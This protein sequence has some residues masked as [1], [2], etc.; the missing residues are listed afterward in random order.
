MTPMRTGPIG[1]LYGYCAT[2]TEV[3]TDWGKEAQPP[4]RCHPHRV[5]PLYLDRHQKLG[6]TVEGQCAQPS[7]PIARARPRAAPRA[8]H[9][10]RVRIAP[11]PFAESN[12][13]DQRRRLVPFIWSRAEDGQSGTHKSM[14]RPRLR[15]CCRADL[16]AK[17]AERDRC[18]RAT[19]FAPACTSG[20]RFVSRSFNEA[21]PRCSAY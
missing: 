6:K 15:L 13:K 19:Y 18:R 4:L 10:G 5:S 7:R 16:P 9:R 11:R 14:I 12:S 2:L 17:I 21:P 3:V 1:L 20:P 8:Y